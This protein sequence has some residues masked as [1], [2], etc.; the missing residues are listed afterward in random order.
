M[1]KDLSSART[2]ARLACVGGDAQACALDA[3]LHADQGRCR[4]LASALSFAAHAKADAGRRAFVAG[5][6]GG[7][8]DV[9]RRKRSQAKACALGLKAAC[10]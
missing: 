4:A 6:G 7:P 8:E 5:C 1:K 2:F 10:P 9:K 3:A